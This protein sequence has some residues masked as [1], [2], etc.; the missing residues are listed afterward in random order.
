MCD[1]THSYIRHD[2]FICATWSFVCATWLIH[3]CEMI[4]SCMRHGLCVC[5]TWLIYMCDMAYSYVRH[6]SIHMCNVAHNSSHT[7]HEGSSMSQIWII[8]VAQ[9]KKSLYTYDHLCVWHEIIHVC[10]INDTSVKWM[11]HIAEMR[12]TCRTYERIRRTY[13]RVNPHVWIKHR[14]R[15]FTVTHTH[16]MRTRRRRHGHR[17]K[18]KIKWR[19]TH[20]YHTRTHTDCSQTKAPAWSLYAGYTIWNPIRWRHPGTLLCGA[21]RIFF[22]QISTMWTYHKTDESCRAYEWVTHMQETW[23]TCEWGAKWVRSRTWTSHGTRMN[24]ASN[25]VWMRRRLRMYE[26]GV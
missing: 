6:D 11:I 4:H 26:W 7:L 23:H 1:M 9:I 14:R 16:A 2:S 17:N 15:T 20:T 18:H 12:E 13:Q 24:E 25:H 21:Y 8:P 19:C 5:A 3:M 10:D 22:L